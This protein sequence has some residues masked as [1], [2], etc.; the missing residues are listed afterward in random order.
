M[1]GIE[2]L[3]HEHGPALLAFERENRGYFA[4]CVPD[5]GDGYFAE[6]DARHAGILAGQAAGQDYFHVLVG[7]D[8]E[9]LGRVNLVDVADGAAELGYRVAEKATGRG[10]ATAAVR[11]VLDLAVSAYGLRTL[12]AVTTRDNAGSHAVLTRTGF[13][14]TGE[15][16]VDDGHLCVRYALDLVPPRR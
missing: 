8:G 16:F 5:R 2:L 10:V 7:A 4:A 12:R 3:R 9:V 1:L 11:Q 6:F 15:T 13:L 14:P